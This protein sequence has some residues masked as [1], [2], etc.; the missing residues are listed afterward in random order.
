MRA[1]RLRMAILRADAD[2]LGLAMDG[3]NQSEGRRQGDLDLHVTLRRTVDCACFGKHGARAVH[4][5]V[6]NDVG[7]FGHDKV[8]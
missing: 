6:S 1:I 2:L 4:L 3:V 5:P 8:L 7:P